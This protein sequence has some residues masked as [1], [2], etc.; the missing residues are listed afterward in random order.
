MSR[1]IAIG[2]AS[3]GLIHFGAMLDALLDTSGKNLDDIHLN[4]VIS[5]TL[6]AIFHKLFYR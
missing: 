2:G 1:V 6:N 4:A 3:I 5:G